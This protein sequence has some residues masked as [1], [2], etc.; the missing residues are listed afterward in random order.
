MPLAA[1]SSDRGSGAAGDNIERLKM[2]LPHTPSLVLQCK[3]NRG[4]KI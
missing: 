1:V 2:T 3:R 4:Q